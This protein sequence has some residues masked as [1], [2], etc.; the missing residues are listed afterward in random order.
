MRAR[1]AWLEEQYNRPS[2]SDYYLMRIAFEVWAV[3]RKNRGTTTLNDFKLKFGED[4]V[5]HP[6]DT[7][8]SKSRWGRVLSAMGAVFKYVSPE[9]NKQR[10]MDRGT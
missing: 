7:T 3:L 5:H 4:D 1:E 2:R 8:E 10:G 6:R 9:E